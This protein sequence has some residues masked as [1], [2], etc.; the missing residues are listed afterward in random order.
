MEIEN[1][2]IIQIIGTMVK[3]PIDVNILKVS[4]FPPGFF[5]APPPLPKVES[6]VSLELY[7]LTSH[8]P[9]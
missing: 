7:R 2:R 8:S 5:T 1:P 3:S 4:H 6:S 9:D